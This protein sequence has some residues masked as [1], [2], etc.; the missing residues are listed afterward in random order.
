MILATHGRAIWVLDHLEPI[1]EYAAAQ[2]VTTDAKLFTLPPYAMFRRPARDR[3]Y[4]FWGDQ[5]FF[6]ENPPPAAVISWLNRKA[7]GEVTL[8]ITDAAGKDVR[9][10]SGPVLANSNKA[11]MQSACWDL[12]VQPAPA[13][14]PVAGRG[15]RG[16]GGSGGAQGQTAAEAQSPFGAGC[17]VPAAAGGG[18]GFG[19]GPVLAG[20]LVIGGVY[21]VAL[22]VDGKTIETKPLRVTNDPE[23]VLTSAERKRM[24]DMAMEIHALQPRVTEAATAHASLTRQMTELATTIGGRT[25]VPAD[26]KASFEALNKELAGLAPKLA[27]PQGGRGGGGGRGA[28]DSLSAR[29]GQAK[30][31]LTAGMTPG[32]QTA[33]A[34]AE[35][36]AQAP[37]AIA[38][39]NAAIAKAATLSGALANYNLTLTVPQPV[40]APDAAPAKKTSNGQRQ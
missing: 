33:R 31:G 32:D 19:G 24:F 7:V 11:G 20:P 30:N 26:V 29:L 28:N 1:Q 15:A 8:R 10:I 38:D 22:I 23:V 18:G 40:K 16:T 2:A 4:E 25:D 6:G 5:T 34:Y 9:G 13:P 14:P 21:N 27:L 17:P 35:V 37:K 36:K 12:R 3:N 39:L